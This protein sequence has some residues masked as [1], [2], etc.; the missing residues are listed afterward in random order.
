MSIP[1]NP[2]LRVEEA[3]GNPNVIPVFHMVVSN[4]SVT[5]LAAGK[6]R[7]DASGG[8]GPA[9]PAGTVTIGSGIT[10]SPV[11]GNALVVGSGGVLAQIDTGVFVRVYAPT[12][13]NYVAFL[14]DAALSNEKVLTAGSS[15][16]ITTDA[17]AIYI[18]A[19]TSP[20]G[21]SPVYAPTGGFYIAFAADA[22]LSAEKVLQASNGTIN[23]NTDATGFFI[24]ANTGAGGGSGAST[25][26]NYIVFS[27]DA[28]LSNEKI[29]QA[30]NATI[31]ITTDATGF[32]IS[33]NTGVSASSPIYA[34]T[35]G[36]YVVYSGMDV[37]SAERVLT[38]GSSVT[39]TTDG[40]A[41]YI[42]A[43][44]SPPGG[45]P[46][47]APTG[48]FYIA[49]AAD[50]NLSAEKILQASNATIN[51]NTDSTGFYI[52]ANTGGGGGGIQTVRIPMALLSIKINSAN[53]FYNAK[54]G[55]QVDAAH[56]TFA[57][58]GLGIATYWCKVPNN[59]NSTENWNLFFDHEPDSGAGGNVA[60][61]LCAQVLSDGSVMDANTTVLLS[62]RSF[63]TYAS[64]TLAI[65]SAA[66]GVMDNTMG[67]AANQT[68]QV[69]FQRLGNNAGDSLNANWNLKNLSV[70]LDVNS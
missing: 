65:T 7:L 12:G 28:G 16:N 20:P 4:M 21:A 52:S 47:Y 34:P 6:I 19:T 43:T 38:A 46:V 30:S 1:P 59:V 63:P 35:G 24:S 68:F 51:I 57:D 44:T 2:F 27:A 11:D 62:A 60:I 14:A 26:G 41:V 5:K 39:I 40:T 49:F 3:D 67:L 53:A 58:S 18:N 13:G 64:G 9:G 61:T 70:Q 32:Y 50:A 45:S 29:L 48:G 56:V 10:G 54:S 42:N 69:I 15:I 37:L 66:T 55:T 36:F 17:S 23:I 8:T 25:A 31:N 33:A 22:N